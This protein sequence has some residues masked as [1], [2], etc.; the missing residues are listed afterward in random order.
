MSSSSSTTTGR[1]P[2]PSRRRRPDSLNG[3]ATSTATSMMMDESSSTAASIGTITPLPPGTA[4]SSLSPYHNH[5]HHHSHRMGQGLVHA[6]LSPAAGSGGMFGSTTTTSASATTAKQP[7]SA[8]QPRRFFQDDDE[9]D[10][11]EEN[12]QRA[13][14][15]QR[16]TQE[17]NKKKE[18]S[19]SHLPQQQDGRA[20]ATS[21]S[22]TNNHQEEM[23]VVDGIPITQ[24]RRLAQQCLLGTTTS[25][26]TSSTSTVPVATPSPNMA[27]FYASLVY[28]KTSDDRDA[29]GYAQALL[30]DGQARRSVQV[31][32]QAGLLS[33]NNHT[34]HYDT[35]N[36]NSHQLLR[37][38]AV[39][40][41]TQA[42]SGLDDWESI[43]HMLH[44][45]SWNP[46]VLQDYNGK[47][48]EDEDNED[49][50]HAWA[51][52]LV[53]P[54]S[55]SS[56]YYIH[57]LARLC[58]HRGTA[59]AET[60]HPVRAAR[61]W[62]LSLKLDPQ[63]VP[64]LDQLLSRSVIT[65]EEAY[66]LIVSLEFPEEMHFL[67]QLYLARVDLSP[68]SSSGSGST[69]TNTTT[70]AF[71]VPKEN[72]TSQPTT[73]FAFGDASSIQ[74]MTTPS[75]PQH[76][77]HPT[78]NENS[79]FFADQDGDNNHK[80]PSNHN[81][82]DKKQQ[83][84]QIMQTTVDQAFEAL[85][86]DYKLD[87]S[88]QVL[89]LAA[90]RAYRRHDWAQALQYCQALAA[91]DPLACQ[92]GNAGFVY[93]STLVALGL[94]R[95]LFQLA[96]EWVDAQPQSARA[97]CAVGAYYMCC[98]RY[99]VAQRHYC[100][101]T[102]LDPQCTEA[103]IGFGCAFAA[104]DESDQALASFRAAQRLAPGEAT[105]L[106]YMGMEY[107]RTNHLVLA[108][109]FLM[110]AHK[111]SGSGSGDPLCSNELGVLAL[112]QQ[113]YDAAIGWFQRAIQAQ[114]ASVVVAATGS[115]TT[116]RSH[117]HNNNNNNNNNNSSNAIRDAIDQCQ[118]KYWEPTLFNLGQAYRK[119]RQFDQAIQCFE[120]CI[121]LNPVSVYICIDCV[122]R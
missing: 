8:H 84:E 57:P 32:A 33:N 60:G 97:W 36:S 75:F 95:P 5:S 102:R 1:S 68:S 93:L 78:S 89:A 52:S 67:K 37:L 56:S 103:W 88:P 12:H 119:T 70:D 74:L 92:N 15:E 39:L 94:K 112:Q 48:D 19:S 120:R 10:D 62:K 25:Y 46:P 121:S 50:W 66:E 23:L 20:T 73:P 109:H 31:L 54:Q 28:S 6:K 2:Y 43:L 114:A 96:H 21:T 41:A 71:Q 80:T 63:C 49:A 59:Y 55:S 91:I 53:P 77:Y 7:H 86:K 45:A 17:K 47:N 108:Q 106:L 51:D 107:L 85:W 69:N 9:E 117:H 42:L 113:D 111:A 35:D 99:H 40:L 116:T 104:C 110:A 44:D 72:D 90:R 118:D 29:F 61:F 83:A 65:S 115:T 24:L 105:S 11:E 79:L 4:R 81:D 122:N 34:Q 76:N 100:R 3:T 22:T 38:E 87:Q 64:A 82:N 98:E 101:A 13:Q 58:W 16:N 27:V 30:A 18:S 26:S 14:P